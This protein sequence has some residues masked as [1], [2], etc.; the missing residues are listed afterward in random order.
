MLAGFALAVNTFYGQAPLYWAVLFFG[1]AVTAATF[2]NYLHREAE[3]ERTGVDYSAE[4]RPDLL[5]YAAG[6][7]LGIMSLAMALPAINFR[8]IA[9]AF[10]RQEAVVAA[11]RTLE[12]AFA[13]VQQPRTDEGAIGAGGLPRSFLLGGDPQPVSYTHLP[14]T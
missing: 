12:R 8:A 13:G 14:S 3:W 2:L 11:E 6:V 1:L 10:Q 4:V 5:V 7:S 9:E